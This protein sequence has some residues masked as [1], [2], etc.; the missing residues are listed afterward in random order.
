VWRFV[1]IQ[2]YDRDY[3][4]LLIPTAIGAIAMV[5]IHAVT[6]GPHWGVD[7]LATGIIGGAVYYVAFLLFGLTPPE[8]QGALRLVGKVT[9]KRAASG[10]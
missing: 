10:A 2:P 4:R 8:R 3:A 5:A 1:R 6:E 9:G 7:L